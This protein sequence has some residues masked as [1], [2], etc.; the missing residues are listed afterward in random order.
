MDIT[1]DYFMGKGI[2]KRVYQHP[3]DHDICIKFPN[4]S[5]KR[6]LNDIKREIKYLKRHQDHLVW[7]APYLGEIETNLGKGYMYQIV[8][9]ESGELSKPITETQ[10]KQNRETVKEKVIVMYEQARVRKAVINDLSLSNIYVRQKAS[11]FDL[12]LID[13]FGN[14]NFVKLADYSRSFL[15]KKL[16]RKFTGLCKR[17]DIKPD[18]LHT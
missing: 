17:F 2:A 4:P 5:K 1:E 11:G 7:L 8:R 3:E 6:A 9:D 13:G 18:F 16:N 12:V 10:W 15:T 14:N